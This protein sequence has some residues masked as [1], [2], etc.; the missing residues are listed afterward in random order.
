MAASRVRLGTV[1]R[2][3]DMTM[4]TI[5]PQ[6]YEALERAHT[7]LSQDG[8]ERNE[9]VQ[10]LNEALQAHVRRRSS[11]ILT[12]RERS[13]LDAERAARTDRCLLGKW[14]LGPGRRY[15]GMTAVQELAAAHVAFHEQSGVIAQAINGGRY[16]EARVTLQ[17]T[18]SGFNRAS[19]EMI[20]LL[21]RLK[22]EL[23]PARLGAKTAP[24]QRLRR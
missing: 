18:R 13:Q 5:A 14:L 12:I 3:E 8:D 6:T 23:A 19:H 15:G 2:M 17:S 24:E 21:V 9:D 10:T 1:L 11:Y 7:L 20:T 4:D 16:D 22:K